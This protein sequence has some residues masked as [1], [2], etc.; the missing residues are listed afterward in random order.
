MEVSPGSSVHHTLAAGVGKAYA[1][2][3]KPPFTANRTTAIA[4]WNCPRKG[5]RRREFGL[6]NVALVFAI[7]GPNPR[8]REFLEHID[9]RILV[10][11]LDEL[12]DLLNGAAHNLA[13]QMIKLHAGVVQERPVHAG[14]EAFHEGPHALQAA[15]LEVGVT[16]LV[17]RRLVP[18]QSEVGSVLAGFER[19]GRRLHHQ[20]SRFL[21]EERLAPAAVEVGEE[22]GDVH[23]GAG[24]AAGG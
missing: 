12:A 3:G 15:V 9:I 8:S 10:E 18:P 14:R 7:D 22:A 5:T 6:A 11:A 2:T 1:P 23:H 13:V 17:H 16:F 20:L 19:L 24:P 21:A 4:A